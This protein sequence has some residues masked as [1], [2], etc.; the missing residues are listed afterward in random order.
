MLR[1]TVTG[2]CIVVFAGIL[3]NF[4][5]DR[6]KI[7]LWKLIGVD[8]DDIRNATNNRDRFKIFSVVYMLEAIE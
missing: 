4:F 7:I 5:D 2:R 6:F 8:Y 1:G 3:A